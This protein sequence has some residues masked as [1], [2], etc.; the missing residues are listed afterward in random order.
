MKTFYR[1][2]IVISIFAISINIVAQNK[3]V[4]IQLRGG[5]NVT[6]LT[7]WD[8]GDYINADPKAGFN[9][10]GIADINV[11]R[12][13]YLQTGL[14]LASKGAKVDDFDIDNGY[15]RAKMNAVYLQVPFYFAYKFEFG[16]WD[17]KLGVSAG[18]YIAYG[19]AGKTSYSSWGTSKKY[20]YDTFQSNGLWNK[21]DAGLGFEAYFELKKLAFIMG[22]EL[23][24][25][26]AWKKKYLLNDISV[27]N[28]TFYIALGYRL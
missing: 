15:V 25:T 16:R 7:A 27:R 10:G 23:G 9:I 19:V 14:V 18:P 13:A 26:N 12:G 8:D 17:N 6:N 11:G 21:F 2:L 3:K 28:N 4:S 24:I 22:S 5:L 1:L 20:N